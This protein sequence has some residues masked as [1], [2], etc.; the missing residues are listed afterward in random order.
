MINNV[1]K[2][3]FQYLDNS[4][5]MSLSWIFLAPRFKTSFGI[6]YLFVKET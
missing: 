5:L 4:S 6:T 1:V 2:K 3:N